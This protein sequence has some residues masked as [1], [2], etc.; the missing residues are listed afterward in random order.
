VC[1]ND[2]DQSL[3]SLTY[4]LAWCV[5]DNFFSIASV[6]NVLIV[7]AVKAAIVGAVIVGAVIVKAFTILER[8]SKRRSLV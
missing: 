2:L 1:N 4:L 8:I 6:A 5:A 7:K 3:F